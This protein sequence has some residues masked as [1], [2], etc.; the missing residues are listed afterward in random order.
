MMIGKRRAVVTALLFTAAL[1]GVNILWLLHDSRPPA[2]DMALH[3][4]YALNYFP[5]VVAA[6]EQPRFW[7]LSGP[8]PP[9][10]HIV[11]ALLYRLFHPGAHVA[12]MANLPATFLLFWALYRLAS[13]LAGDG[14]AFWTCTLTALTPLLIWL[15][16]ETIL[17]YWLCAWVAATLVMMRRTRDF[18]DHRAALLFGCTLGFGMLTKW[19]FAA[20]LVA[21]VACVCV[22]SHIWREPRRAGHLADALIVGQV[23]AAPWYLPNLWSLVGYFFENLRTGVL[24]GEPPV[25]SFQS[26]IYYLRLLEGYQ[27]FG[28]LFALSVIAIIIVTARRLLPEV[29]LLHS[30]IAGGWLSMTLLRTKDPRFTMPLLGLLLIFPARWLSSLGGGYGPKVIKATLVALLGFQAY[31]VNFGVSWLPQRIILAE[32]Y[33]G[34]Q[35]WDWNL[36]TQE[37]YGIFGRPRREDWKMDEI[38]RRILQEATGGRTPVRLAVVPDLPQFNHQ[39]LLWRARLLGLPIRPDHPQSAARGIHSFDEFDF[40]L[41]TEGDQGEPWSTRENG[42]LNRIILDHPERFRLVEMYPL[43]NGDFIRLYLCPSNGE[44]TDAVHPA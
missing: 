15:S 39:T 19:L 41:M 23:I 9:F 7:E 27:L 26:L 4:T 13:D 12:A 33:Q 43:P 17:D 25:L 18:A 42:V 34:S 5:G 29:A 6:G 32:G 10:V 37:F 20:F 14:A 38:F 21:P 3:Q 2:W 44:A 30:T 35:R 1:W 8:Y 11:I 16:R 24:E 28:L 31:A 22:R 40:V 36:Y